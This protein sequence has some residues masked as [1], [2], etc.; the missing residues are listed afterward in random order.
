[1][2]QIAAPCRNTSRPATPGTALLAPDGTSALPRIYGEVAEDLSI[3]VGQSIGL[4]GLGGTPAPVSAEILQFAQPV[5]RLAAATADPDRLESAAHLLGILAER[6]AAVQNLAAHAAQLWREIRFFLSAELVSTPVAAADAAPG[7]LSAIRATLGVHRGSIFVAEPP[8]LKP[9]ATD[10]IDPEHVLAIPIDDPESISAWVFR[11]GAP[12]LVNDPR[13]RPRRLKAR[14]LEL[15]PE[16]HDGFLSIP[17]LLPDAERTP[18]GVLNLAGHAGGRFSPEDVKVA[19]AMAQV[20]ALAL[21]RA[22]I[23]GQALASARL[24]EELRL[25]AEMHAG[26]S[27]THAPSWPGFEIAAAT[28][29]AAGGIAGGDYYDF[30]P[31]KGS[32]NIIVADVQG[33]GLGAAL[34]AGSVRAALRTALGLGLGP[35][36]AL[37][38]LNRTL[39]Q[40]NGESGLFASAAVCRLAGDRFTFAAAGHPPLIRFGKGGTTFLPASGPPAGAVPE[41]EYIEEEHTLAPG[42]LLA[43]YSDGLL[44]SDGDPQPAV[45]ELGAALGRAAGRDPAA[46]VA[47]LIE[48][49]PETADDRTLVVVRRVASLS[50]NGGER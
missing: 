19:T 24:R 39:A 20:A 42:D 31:G 41:A 22:R 3:L 21:H 28:R 7:L 23:T 43:L 5:G 1:M 18:V 9:V 17:L 14:G 29:P 47:T 34:C 33:H 32:L 35:G 46:I 8:R 26:L 13:R 44:G 30:V 2:N 49:A 6:E 50:S 25:A 27:P 4:A 11:H 45:S 10:G 37:A 16:F 48:S 15:P 36:A 40:T 12:L 38:A